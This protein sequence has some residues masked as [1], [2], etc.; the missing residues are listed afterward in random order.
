ME[1]QL[2]S[3]VYELVASMGNLTLELLD[4]HWKR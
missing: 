4:L 1:E 2:S 3:V